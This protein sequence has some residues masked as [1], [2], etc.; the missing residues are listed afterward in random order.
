MIFQKFLDCLLKDSSLVLDKISFEPAL[1]HF[2]S[3][4]SLNPS[5]PQSPLIKVQNIIQLKVANFCSDNFI[6][7][8]LSPLWEKC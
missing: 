3:D 4:I 8:D 1:S 2:A 6:Y 5:R 7:P